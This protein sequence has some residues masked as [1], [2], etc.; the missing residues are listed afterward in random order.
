MLPMI[1]IKCRPPGWGVVTLILYAVHW[2]PAGICTPLWELVEQVIQF[3][4]V[5]ND[6]FS[7][8]NFYEFFSFEIAERAYQ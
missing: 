6:D 1:I 4:Q 5:G 7:V 8:F 2:M 3:F